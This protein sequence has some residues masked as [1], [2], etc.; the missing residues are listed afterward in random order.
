MHKK[1]P[2]DGGLICDGIYPVSHE[3][4]NSNSSVVAVSIDLQSTQT[5]GGAFSKWV[6]NQ[7]ISGL[8]ANL[9]LE[10]VLSN[11]TYHLQRYIWAVED[12]CIIR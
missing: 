3:V 2:P 11:C 9:G 5:L 10:G 7:T 4:L 12:S 8:E 6:G 1:R